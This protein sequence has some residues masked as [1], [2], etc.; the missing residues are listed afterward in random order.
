MTPAE[1]EEMLA[2]YAAVVA[3]RDERIRSAIAA[4]L[5][6][7]RVHVLTGVARTTIDKIVASGD[8]AP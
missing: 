8:Q 7:H 1:A 2:E 6:K 5:A 3:S 4:G